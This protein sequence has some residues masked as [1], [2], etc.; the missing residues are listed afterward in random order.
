[1]GAELVGDKALQSTEVSDICFLVPRTI[2]P[3]LVG[4]N[5]ANLMM[6][7]QK[8]GTFVRLRETTAPGMAAIMV[9]DG[10]WR[11]FLCELF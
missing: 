3:I 4:P 2:C 10:D 11:T 5:G 6:L 8:L 1:M 7:S 9:S